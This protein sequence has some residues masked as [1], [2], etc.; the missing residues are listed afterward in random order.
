[1]NELFQKLK[2]LIASADSDMNKAVGGNHAA[3]V[4]VRKL[5]QEIK[6]TA[7]EIRKASL[8]EK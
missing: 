4:R 8:V 7:Q 3:S 5:M 2:D 1:M 6:N